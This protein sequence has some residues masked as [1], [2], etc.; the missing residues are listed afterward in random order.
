M[1]ICAECFIQQNNKTLMLY[2]NKKENDINQGKWIGLGGKF[3]PGESPEECLVRE[4]KEEAGVTVTDYKLRGILT[5]QIM[6]NLSEPLYI[7]IYTV[8]AYEGEIGVC[9]EGTLEW[10]DNDKILD[11]ELWEGDRLFWGWLLEDKG[12]FSANFKYHDDKLI[13]YKVE[14]YT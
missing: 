4:V 11:L 5:F 7:F 10:I 9:D 2:R 3:E 1:V 12:F 14:F 13:D 8:S 6:E